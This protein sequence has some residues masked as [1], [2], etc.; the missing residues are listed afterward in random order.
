M[1]IFNHLSDLDFTGCSKAKELAAGIKS[2]LSDE[3]KK[4]KAVLK[5]DS[6]LL[7]FKR[8]NGVNPDEDSYMEI[9]SEEID[10]EDIRFPVIQ[11]RN[12]FLA[13]RAMCLKRHIEGE[14]RPLD[15]NPPTIEVNLYGGMQTGPVKPSYISVSPATEDSDATIVIGKIKA[16]KP[17]VVQQESS[18]N[19]IGNVPSNYALF[20]YG[21]ELVPAGKKMSVVVEIDYLRKNTDSVNPLDPSKTRFEK[22]FFGKGGNVVTFGAIVDKTF[23]PNG[24]TT[25]IDAHYKPIFEDAYKGRTEEEAQCAGDCDSCP[26]KNLCQYAHIPP[27]IEYERKL[28]SLKDVVLSEPQQKIV[29]F[30]SGFAVVDAGPGGG[31]TLALMYSYMMLLMSGVAPEEILVITFTDAAAK[32]LIHRIKAGCEDFGLEVDESKMRIMTFNAFGGFLINENYKLLGFDKEPMLLDEIDRAADIRKLLEAKR[33]KGLRYDNFLMNTFACKGALPLTKAIFDICKKHNLGRGCEKQLAKHIDAQNLTAH[34]RDVD[35][36]QMLEIYE[37]FDGI[38]HE[39]NLIQY[40]DQIQSIFKLLKID[41]ILIENL[42]IRHIRVDE[43]QDTDLEQMEILKKLIDTPTFESLMLIGDDMQSI[44]GFRGTTPYNL[45]HCDEIFGR[46]FERISMLENYR[47]KAAVNELANALVDRQ[48]DATPK[49]IISTRMED[50]VVEVKGFY[51]KLDELN[52]NADLIKKLVEDEG[53]EPKSICVICADKAT[54]EKY[55]DA[56]SLRGIPSVSYCPIP[57]LENSNVKAAIAAVKAIENPEDTQSIVE[58]VNAILDGEYAS[59]D[60]QTRATY[61]LGF[62]EEAKRIK[63][64]PDRRRVDEYMKMLVTFDPQEEDEIFYSFMEKAKWHEQ[65]WKHVDGVS[66]LADY[67]LN[68]EMYGEKEAFKRAKEYPGVA[69]TTA[70]SSK[71]LE[72]P[73]VFLTLTG[74]HRSTLGPYSDRLSG[75]KLDDFDERRRLV[76]VAVT[77]AMDELYIS[78]VYQAFNSRS[79]GSVRNRFLEEV[80]C[81]LGKGSEYVPTDPNAK[82]KKE[83]EKER[84]KELARKR[85]ERDIEIQKEMR[86]KELESS[87][88]EAAKASEEVL[89]ARARIEAELFGL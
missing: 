34:C 23:Y 31:K 20:R 84:L 78:G 7:N 76:Y 17:K 24:E 39:Q 53:R 61:V 28:K 47:S 25:L 5:A 15:L 66:G 88:A 44:F 62:Q 9:L 54:I 50:A 63:S 82:Q 74:F 71:G 67:L 13:E 57:Y 26:V 16:G 4:A 56:L 59:Y 27:A 11:T 58:C 36:T 29:D 6:R 80:F 10:K 75:K 32:E 45:V 14:M 87:P 89:E 85:L 40:D 2:T 69:L 49:K 68:F 12:E 52:Y 41:P 65:C 21:A 1:A 22:E 8:E 73:T 70:H 72:W 35:L 38:L 86:E 19:W 55:S 37:L 64:L 42:G 3:Q 48:S 60:E 79:T 81:D 51:N 46:T 83:A 77:R 43:A 33:V 18:E 30:T